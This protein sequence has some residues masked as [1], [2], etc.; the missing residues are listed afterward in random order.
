VPCVSWPTTGQ[1]PDA[2]DPPLAGADAL[3]DAGVAA[4]ASEHQSTS[5]TIKHVADVRRHPARFTLSP[6]S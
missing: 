6:E 3:P 4:T 1:S 2:A 5:A